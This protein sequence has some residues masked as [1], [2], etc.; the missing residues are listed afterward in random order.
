MGAG[1]NAVFEDIADLIDPPIGKLIQQAVQSIP[2][3]VATAL[4]F[5][6]GS[7]YRDSHG[8]HSES[9]NTSRVTPNVA[10][11]YEVTACYVTQGMTTPASRAVAIRLNGTTLL[12]PG[13]RD[14][15]ATITS[16]KEVTTIVDI[17]G[18]G[19]YFEAM[20]TQDSAAAVNTSA[21]LQ[22]AS[23]LSWKRIGPL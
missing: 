23:T 14:A 8:Q 13:P 22:L 5:G 17:N 21:T 16:S 12:A 10:G 11:V 19:D 2:D 1:D 9:V 18:T 7:T 6:A 20:A 15:G 4:T 3:N